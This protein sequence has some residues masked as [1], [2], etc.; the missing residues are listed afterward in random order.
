MK[1][2]LLG[3]LTIF[4]SQL[5]IGQTLYTF[6]GGGTTGNWNDASIWT[7]DP[8]GSTSVGAR[9]PDATYNNVVVTNSFTV[10]V[11]AAVPTTGLSI[12]IQKGGVLDLNNAAYTAANPAFPSLARLAGQGTLRIAAPYFPVVAANANDFDDIN[13][14]TVEYY[15]WPAG[16]M[17]L[18]QPA[19]AQYNNLRLLNTTGT[20]TT[21]GTAFTALINNNLTINGNLSLTN[22]NYIKPNLPAIAGNLGGNVAL[23]MGKV[24][25]SNGRTLTVQG[26]V[27]IGG[28]T[29]LGVAAVTTTTVHTLNVGGNF[30][31]N[32]TVNLHNGTTNDN[33]VVLLNFIGNNDATFACNGPTDLNI[34][35]V[36]KGIDS[37]VLLNVTS[38]VNPQ[39]A[40]GNLRLNNL[41][42]GD[43][44]VLVNGVVKLNN[45]IVL[46]KIHNGA[47]ADT[48]FG[49]GTPSTSP[50]L[51]IA[52]ATVSNNNANGLVVYGT[53]RI[54]SGQFSSVT[55]DAMVIREDGQVLI[56]GGTTTVD[57]F[58]PSNTS[59]THR[60]SFIITG[61]L[62][63]VVGTFASSFPSTYAARFAIPYNTQ[64]LRMTGGTIRVQN[65]NNAAGVFHIGVDP[66]N[67]VVT[68]GTV[69]VVLTN[70]TTN[71]SILTTAPL[72]NLNITKSS[73]S[74][75][76]KAILNDITARFTAG[77]TVVAQPLTVLNNFGIG[78]TNAATFDA[79]SQNVNIQGNFTIATNGTYL[80]TTNTTTF[81]GSQ[82]QLLTN[83]GTIGAAATPNTFYRWVMDKSAGTLTLGGTA[84]TYTVSAGTTTAPG[85]LSLL[86]GVLNDGGKTINVLGNMVNSASHT[87]GGGTGSITMAGS[88]LQTISGNDLGVFGNLTIA[89]TM[90]NTAPVV[91]VTMTANISVSNTLNF[92][93]K[94]ILAIGAN[95]LSLTNVSTSTA[96]TSDN[97][98]DNFCFVQT[99]GNQSDLG[100]Q[101]TYGGAD[102]FTFPVGTGTKFAQAIVN[103][104]LATSLAKYGQ[105]SVSPVNAKNPFTTTA[106]ALKYYWKV[107][108]V[109][110]GTIP[111]TAINMSFRLTSTDIVGTRTAY[112]PG[113]YNPVA[114]TQP[115]GA[116]GTGSPNAN[117]TFSSLSQ[118]EGEFTAG[119][120]G[121]FGTVT[122][123][124]SR[125]SGNWATASTWSTT[126][127]AVA[128]T[129]PSANNPVFI[130]SASTNVFH[131]VTVAANNA[132]SGSLVIDRGSVMDIGTTTGHNF[133][134]LPDAKVGGSGRLRVSS[135]TATVTFPSG[136]FGSFLQ[137]NGGTV[138]Y[139]TTS[140]NL[141]VPSSSG[142]LSLNSY[143]NLWL[144]ASSGRTITLPDLNL[145]VFAQLKTGVA[146]GATTYPGTVLLSATAN[147][148][149]RVDS[150]VAVQAGALRYTNALARTLTADTD[151]RIDAGAT[152]DVATSTATTVAN[153][154]TVGGSLTN[155]GILDF[156]VGTGAVNLNFVG[157]QSANF[158]GTTGTLTELYTLSMNK[159][160]G[161]AAILNLDMAGTLTTPGSG[162]LTLTNGTL[163]YAK[164]AGSTL[165]IHNADSQYLIPD[166]A[167][168][169]V[170]APGADVTIA[171]TVTAP[172]TGAS[173]AADLKLAG[174]LK[175]MQGKLSIGTTTG[176]GNDLE[177][178]SAGTPT[179]RV[180]N[181]GTLYVN[182]QIRRTTANTNGSLRY[183]QSG[184]TVEIGGA[185]AEVY[186]NN[187]R[188]LL[189]VQ[190]P[191]SIFRMT[192][193]TLALR[194]T[195]T[196]PTIIG[197]L[198]LRPDSTVV[199]AGTVVLGNTTS[200]AVTVSVESL[201]PLYDV[202]VESGI[203]ATSTNTGLLTG[204][205]PLN[206]KGSLTIANSNAYFNANGLNL[207]I[208]QDLVNNNA[209]TNT[210]LTNGGFQPGTATQTTTFTRQGPGC[211]AAHE[212]CGQPDGIWWPGSQQLP[213]E[214]H[215]PVGTQCSRHRHADHC[216]RHP[217]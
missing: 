216:Q 192:G 88:T 64:S 45:N 177:Y 34:M 54:S 73:A 120:P 99:S 105:V 59:A 75:T 205:S 42:E 94:H 213:T 202:K 164:G 123:Y 20:P 121:A 146:N 135:T 51:W 145:R 127:A 198:Y 217:G 147:G 203:N 5:A 41:A 81:S 57:K 44:L 60:G 93:N 214:R 38:S 70:T 119:E 130:G 55:Y 115:N 58:R 173:A 207:N 40:N 104:Q 125:T 153:T 4:W 210:G 18:P 171:T 72:W 185:R 166:N 137:E 142:S 67:A 160:T 110:F 36:N 19:S 85:T 80:P 126:S 134:A 69:E 136:D 1:A 124:Y 197:D 183:D 180:G 47:T 200:S 78:G 106:N 129:P 133:G 77:A 150:L 22:T 49:V 29:N 201:V 116:V 31:N 23:N 68:G 16:T 39:S 122:A 165:T 151:V 211:A 26:N 195:N 15:N 62:F 176:L 167:G 48:F 8:T 181:G 12:T 43:L 24:G 154:L 97:G 82:N 92:A 188:G 209:S 162:W 196:R 32:G 215:V 132:S 6:N 184:G 175:V 179:I 33:Q 74:G 96:I 107:R 11:N 100:L 9:V 113:R 156:K 148:N 98:F 172:A 178:A 138:E 53:Y 190:G 168:L 21:T 193:G 139:Y 65:P 169:T 35:Q 208:D 102:N 186:Q 46:P 212:Q 128:S 157:G 152:L 170:D 13:T 89:S 109:G 3:L 149:L 144:N 30:V 76:S 141:T 7:T 194:G 143:R 103:L 84:S 79:N 61:G 161:Q 86:N 199:T 63:D 111:A 27:A 158:T 14:G 191:G 131:T 174:Q 108:S 50:T 206:L 114:W 101:K 37:Q 163:R 71:A 66:N 91:A 87:S 182:G 187:E 95:R 117:I 140:S 10:Y 118:F 83:N 204:L 28:G 25:V 2:F 159:G 155:N 56:E 17:D 189:E 90:A 52:G 112:I